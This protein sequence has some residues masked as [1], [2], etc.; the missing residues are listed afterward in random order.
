MIR[1]FVRSLQYQDGITPNARRRFGRRMKW[2]CSLT[3]VGTISGTIPRPAADVSC[4]ETA[5]SAVGLPLTVRPARRGS[6]DIG[7]NPVAIISMF[8]WP[9]P[10]RIGP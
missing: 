3:V 2:D 5:F 7:P 1:V 8:P 9:A 4:V 10:G 6:A